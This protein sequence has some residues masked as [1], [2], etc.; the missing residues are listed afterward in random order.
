MTLGI[1]RRVTLIVSHQHDEVCALANGAI[2]L[3]AGR[4]TWTGPSADLPQI[5]NRLAV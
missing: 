4:I 2:I 5:R 3:D 1:V